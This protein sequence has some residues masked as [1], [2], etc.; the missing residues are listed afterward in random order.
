M[1]ILFFLFSDNNVNVIFF[2]KF[3]LQV[4]RSE[5]QNNE[6]DY[7]NNRIETFVRMVKTKKYKNK[8]V[9]VRFNSESHRFVWNMNCFLNLGRSNL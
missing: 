3:T 7:M 8:C 1:F 6:A 9:S 5:I 2:V 4:F